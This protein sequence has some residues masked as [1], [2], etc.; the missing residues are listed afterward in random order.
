MRPLDGG[1]AGKIGPRQMNCDG[2]AAGVLA[3]KQVLAAEAANHG[4]FGE[5]IRGG[6]KAGHG[7]ALDVSLDP[8]QADHHLRH[9]V[10]IQGIAERRGGFAWS[11][12]RS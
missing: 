9:A 2:G 6:R 11:M 10:T 7:D 8:Q 12:R 4:P 3:A 1:R 5:I